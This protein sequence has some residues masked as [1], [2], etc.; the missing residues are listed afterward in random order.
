MEIIEICLILVHFCFTGYL[1]DCYD[2]LG[3]RYQ[4][5]VYVLS[6][7]SN[8]QR[9]DSADD[10]NSDLPEAD[11]GDE[12][13]V[14]LRI[15][16]GKD[17]KLTVRNKHTVG[18]IKRI[19]AKAEN[20]SLEQR[21]FYGGK[22]LNDKLRIEELHVPKGHLIQVVIPYEQTINTNISKDCSFDQNSMNPTPIS[23]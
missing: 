10:P 18:K 4:L 1:T 5:P 6:Q 3:N 17:L 11:L 23:S 9:E 2:E 12:V 14:K 21:W 22:L 8:L 19:L 20:L 16:T 13:I 7:P 15:S